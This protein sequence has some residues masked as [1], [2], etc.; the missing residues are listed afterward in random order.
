LIPDEAVARYR[1]AHFFCPRPI[2]LHRNMV[3]HQTVRY[4][5]LHLVIGFAGERIDY[6][7]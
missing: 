4:S 3:L 2:W 1:C 5:S 7:F 6:R